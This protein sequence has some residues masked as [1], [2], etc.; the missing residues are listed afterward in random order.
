MKQWLELQEEIEYW[1]MEDGEV[2]GE[3]L[4]E[5]NRL[6]ATLPTSPLLPYR[7]G[8]R[9]MRLCRDPV[10]E[11][12]QML[13]P[14]PAQQPPAPTPIPPL[15]MTLHPQHLCRDTC[16]TPARDGGMTPAL[17]LADSDMQGG[18]LPICLKH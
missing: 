15:F 11:L 8:N 1:R 4:P 6:S 17:L 9:L 2:S 5:G 16:L 13:Q 3:W 10:L 7:V 18:L 14:S 12:H